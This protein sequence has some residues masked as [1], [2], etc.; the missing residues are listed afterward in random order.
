MSVECAGIHRPVCL[1]GQDHRA[2]YPAWQSPP[3]PARR[4]TEKKRLEPARRL[5]GRLALVKLEILILA[6]SLAAQNDFQRRLRHYERQRDLPATTKEVLR[7]VC[8]GLRTARRSSR[9]RW[10]V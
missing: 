6:R 8:A 2:N 1:I 5:A 7:A 4:F 3:G 9:G 10:S